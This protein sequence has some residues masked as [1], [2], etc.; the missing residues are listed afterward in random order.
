MTD[1]A[2]TENP[3]DLSLSDDEL[4]AYR[5]HIT[6]FIT[7]TVEAAG[8][9]EAIIALSG[10]IDST[11]TAHLAVEALGPDT[12]YGLVL[13]SE[14]NREGNMS[15]AERVASDLLGIEYEV[16]EIEPLVEAVVGAVPEAMTADDPDRYRTAVGNLR[17]RLRAVLNY[18]A[19][20]NRGGV[21]LGTGNKSEALAG[22]YTKYGD[23]AVD[24]LPIAPLYKQQVRQL[25]RHVGVPEDLAAKT[26]SAELW[27]DQTDEEELG[28]DYDT[29]DSIL[30]L[31]VDGPL[32]TAATARHLAVEE[33]LVERV[34]GLYERSAHKREFPPGPDPLF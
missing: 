5:D 16:V 15:D 14:V 1:V 22:Y 13:P 28:L 4:D 30:A 8:A 24:C 11:L 18:F 3:L 2:R 10:G 17:A 19:A 32:S 31:H 20:N 29:L 12:V 34:R 7:E 9:D 26:A 25:A 33:S 23:G 6:T 21:V 27:A